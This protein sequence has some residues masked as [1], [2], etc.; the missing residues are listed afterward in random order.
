[1]RFYSRPATYWASLV[2]QRLHISYVKWRSESVTCSAQSCPT[3][4]DPMAY[5]PPGSSVH[6]V[7]QARILEWVA[8]PFSRGPSPSR[9]RTH[10]SCI[11][12]QGD[13]STSDNKESLLGYVATCNFKF[14]ICFP[15]C[16]IYLCLKYTNCVI[17]HVY[18]GQHTDKQWA[19]NIISS[20]Y[21]PY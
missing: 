19:L 9:D 14:F 2:A 18:N 6:G 20:S 17:L 12:L 4:C 7:L 1:M 15:I 16:K 10:V 3:L 5:G 8:I 13:S 21:P 11:A